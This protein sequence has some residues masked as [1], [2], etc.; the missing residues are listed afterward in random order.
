MDEAAE[1]SADHGRGQGFHHFGAGARAPRDRQEAGHNGR[2][3][4][5]FRA[6]AQ[7]GAVFDGVDQVGTSEVK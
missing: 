7:A 4:H 2:D 3:G 1:H 6:E 5:D